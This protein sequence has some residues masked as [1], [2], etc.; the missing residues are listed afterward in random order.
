MSEASVEYRGQCDAWWDAHGC[1]LIDWPKGVTGGLPQHIFMRCVM[2]AGHD[3]LPGSPTGHNFGGLGP[4]TPG[5]PGWAAHQRAA[6]LPDVMQG[7]PRLMAQ[8]AEMTDVPAG[9][10]ERKRELAVSWEIPAGVP[11][12]Q[13]EVWSRVEKVA[14]NIAIDAIAQALTV[15]RNECQPSA[16]GG[17]VA[18]TMTVDAGRMF[19]QA[20]I[21]AAARVSPDARVAGAEQS[22]EEW[23]QWGASRLDAAIRAADAGEAV[24]R[25]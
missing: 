18:L 10:P 14:Q 12:W 8:I 23:L 4:Y 16:A 11:D 17:R 13:R 3:P 21:Y 19:W 9:T 6:G 20:L 15:Q 2:E 24:D 22:H 1:Q 7:P 5:M 25:G